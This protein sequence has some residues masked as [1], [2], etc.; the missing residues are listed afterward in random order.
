MPANPRRTK[1]LPRNRPIAASA[2][3]PSTHPNERIIRTRAGA[4]R[5]KYRA[6]AAQAMNSAAIKLTKII[7][8]KRV[9]RMNKRGPRLRLEEDRTALGIQRL[10][11]VFIQVDRNLFI[12]ARHALHYTSNATWPIDKNPFTREQRPLFRRTLA[13]RTFPGFRRLPRWRESSLEA[14]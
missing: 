9:T 8:P 3:A 4:G 7:N 6:P 1:I 12:C 2:T 10:R 14:R 13:G 5:S 11:F